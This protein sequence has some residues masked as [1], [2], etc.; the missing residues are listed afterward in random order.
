MIDREAGAEDVDVAIVGARVGGAVLAAV[1]GDL[2]HRVVVVDAVTFPS[3]TISTHFFRGAGLGAV[4]DRLGVL[5]AVLDLGCPPLTSQYNY[6]GADPTPVAGPPQDPG[7]LGY[8]LSCRRL[9]LDAILVERARRRPTVDIRES[10]VFRDVVRDGDRVAGI[11]VDR[12]GERQAIRARIV[13]G[14]DGRGSRVARSVEAGE[15]RREPATRALYF[16]YVRGFGGPGGRWD[17]PEFSV[18][19]DE[20]AYVFPSDDGVACVAVSVNLEGFERL[21]HDLESVFD[22]RIAAHPGIAE[23]YANSTRL[24][25]VLGTGPKDSIVR[26]ASGPGW[27]LVGDASLHQDPWSGLGMDNAGIHATFL[28]DAIHGWLSGA[29]AEEAA[30]AEFERRRDEHAMPGFE[31]TSTYG[32]D[33]RQFLGEEVPA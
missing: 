17:G 1:L 5:D 25:R 9:P 18:I 13:V 16:R 8:G 31:A 4:L 33:F 32:R 12:G 14:A 10:T 3:D 7:E 29:V 24:G 11:I 15:L 30:F 21:R 2:G 19:D 20:M 6:A 27:A 23:R 26:K 28:A 22:E